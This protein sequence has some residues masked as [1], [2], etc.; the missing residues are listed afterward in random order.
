MITVAVSGGFDPVHSGHIQL[1]AEAREL[2]DE[3]VVILNSDR[4]LMEKKGF[5]FMP[6][7]ERKEIIESI[8]WVDEVV[9]CIDEDQTVCRTLGLVKPDIFANGGDRVEGTLP[10]AEELVCAQ[11]G[12]RMIYGLAK[13]KEHI[14]SSVIFGALAAM[15]EKRVGKKRLVFRKLTMTVW[16]VGADGTFL[17]DTGLALDEACLI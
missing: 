13:G 7:E 8:R 5:V 17:H 2:G 14:H 15:I 4:F 6:F 9:D 11:L 3:L 10:K 12:I 1:F 16:E